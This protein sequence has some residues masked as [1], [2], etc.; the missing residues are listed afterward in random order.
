[1]I[2]ANV[3]IHKAI[4]EGRLRIAPE[5]RPRLPEVGGPHCPYDT[6]SVDLTLGNIISVP[7]GGNFDIN[8]AKPGDIAATI[9]RNCEHHDL[10]QVKQFVL[11][12]NKFILGK[13]REAIELPLQK[14]ADRSL[15]A[16]IEGKSSRARFGLIIHF[17]AP[18]VHPG[19]EGTITL[20]I[21]NLGVYG[22]TLTPGMPIAQLIIEE[23][24]GVPVRNDSQFQ[25]QRHPAGVVPDGRK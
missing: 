16:R 19:F 25:G 12:P 3:E 22:F 20:E 21:I 14:E 11:A 18:T 5:P 10:S 9:G 24:R 15:A 2:L 7:L 23:V 8:L 1:M 6:H 4:D 17:T 13:T